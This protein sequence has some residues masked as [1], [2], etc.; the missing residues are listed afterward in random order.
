MSIA[1]GNGHAPNTLVQAIERKRAAA[2]DEV[3]MTGAEVARLLRLRPSTVAD[4]ARRH[5]LPSV[6]LGRHRRYDV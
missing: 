4:M 5:D 6:M 3:V 2:A 1:N